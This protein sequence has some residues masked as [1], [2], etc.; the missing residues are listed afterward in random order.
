MNKARR[1]IL[2]DLVSVLEDAREKL[3]GVASDEREYY[4]NMP[5][6]MQQGDKGLQADSAAS[7][8]ESATDELQSVIDAI[9]NA[10]AQ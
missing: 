5:E 8:L 9:S 2:N 4:E 1:T 6:N 7:E 3:E 10:L